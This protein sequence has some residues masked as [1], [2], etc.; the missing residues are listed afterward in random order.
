LK[1][2]AEIRLQLVLGVVLLGVL[3]WLSEAFVAP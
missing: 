1:G 3:V 2:G